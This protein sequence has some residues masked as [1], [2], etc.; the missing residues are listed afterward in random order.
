VDAHPNVCP[1]CGAEIP[2]GGKC[3][4]LFHE[5]SAYTI[6]TGDERFIHQ[7]VVDAYAAQHAAENPKPIATTAALIGLHLFAEKGWTGRDAQRAHMELGNRMKE[8]PAFA[9][10]REPARVNVAT[11]LAASAGEPRD[12]AIEVWARA[13]WESWKEEHGRIEALLEGPYRLRTRPV[14]P[15][16]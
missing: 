3:R 6:S 5:L 4:D 10:P 13:V 12:R 15:R 8:W 2:P 1:S 14:K 11:V 16:S 7:H 9:P